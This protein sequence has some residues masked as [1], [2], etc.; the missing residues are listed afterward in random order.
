MSIIKYDMIMTRLLS[1]TYW[2]ELLSLDGMF[3]FSRYQYIRANYL[4]LIFPS[5]I[6]YNEPS[7]NLK[8]YCSSINQENT[9]NCNVLYYTIKV[10]GLHFTYLVSRTRLLNFHIQYELHD[11]AIK[12]KQQWLGVLHR[13]VL[14]GM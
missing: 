6:I 7:W 3:A 9:S 14:W 2:Y 8:L 1:C 11:K 13:K 4:V 10:R 5:I 12:T